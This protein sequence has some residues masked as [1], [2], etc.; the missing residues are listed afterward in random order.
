MPERPAFSKTVPESGGHVRPSARR[1]ALVE[2][3]ENHARDGT[4]RL[5]AVWDE[6]SR[7]WKLRLTE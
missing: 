3:V 6:T 5:V 4:E 7:R 1:A 2:A